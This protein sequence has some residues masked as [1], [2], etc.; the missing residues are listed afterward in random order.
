MR[1]GRKFPLAV[2]LLAAM[3]TLAT[4]VTL[5][6]C[7]TINATIT[8][9]AGRNVMLLGHD[10][11]AYFNMGRPMRGY[12]T[13]AATHEG[14]TYFFVSA[15]HR[16]TFLKTPE[17]YEPQYGAFCSNGEA[18]G[19]KLGSDPTE[20]E[21][22][23]GRLFIFGDILGREFW[24]MNYRFN[25]QKADELWPEMKNTPWREQYARRVWGNK[26][27]WYKTGPELRAEWMQRNPGQKLEYDTGGGLNN[28]V[29]KYPG[30]RARE[31]YSQP[32]VGFVGEE[33]AVPG[34][35]PP[36]FQGYRAPLP[37]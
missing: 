24:K 13:I 31:G 15:N 3:A 16:D 33:G 23:D 8:D 19:I 2:V 34:T 27:P 21:I 5:N 25:I 18:Y 10:P 28:F 6:G 7:G 11:V 17:K 22:I 1:Q 37:Q 32:R 12:P 29:L 35:E 36:V 26:V 30:W 14:K 4:L 20:Y 9:N